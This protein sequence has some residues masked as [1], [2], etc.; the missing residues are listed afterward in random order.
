M[1]ATTS[2]YA[3]LLT[4][5]LLILST[6]VIILRNRERVSIGTGNSEALLRATRVQGNFSEYVP[7]GLI[8]MGL[9][10]LQNVSNWQ[11]HLLGGLLILGRILH[12]LGVSGNEKS[13]PPRIAGMA[14]TFTMLGLASIQLLFA[15]L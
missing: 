12:F 6:R 14:M 8:L 11:I 3:A 2:I 1:L 15:A 5:L 10:E 9:N 7:L 4:A 13:L